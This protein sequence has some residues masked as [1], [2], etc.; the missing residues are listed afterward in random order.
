MISFKNKILIAL[1]GFVLVFIL[2]IVFV[3][4]PLGKSIPTQAQ[5]LLSIRESIRDANVKN[6]DFSVWKVKKTDL[7][8]DLERVEEVYVN[9]ELPLDFLKY[10]ELTARESNLL[11]EISLV[12]QKEVNSA[13]NLKLN[14]LGSP[15]NCLMF[16][17]KIESSPYLIKL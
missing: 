11:I 14:L 13:L 17:E 5:E 7:E 1:S 12:P 2:A 6:Q 15:A 4:Y 3:I 8:K 10:L 16:L 9:K